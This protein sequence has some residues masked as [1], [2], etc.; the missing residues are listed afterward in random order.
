[1]ETVSF[2]NPEGQGLRGADRPGF[3]VGDVD[4]E[5]GDLDGRDLTDGLAPQKAVLG[6]VVA[7]EP[8]MATTEKEVVV[9][10]GVVGVVVAAALAGVCRGGGLPR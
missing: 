9:V 3:V 2:Q 6:G 5:R 10:V 1:M 7:E 4:G 8:K